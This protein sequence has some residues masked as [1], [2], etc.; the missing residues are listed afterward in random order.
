MSGHATPS[1]G[2]YSVI[3]EPSLAE[4][5]SIRLGGKAIAEIRLHCLEGLEAVPDLVKRLGGRL[6]L[7]GEGSNV[8]ASDGRLPLVPLRLPPSHE[9]WICGDEGGSALLRAE[10]GMRLPALLAQA[11]ILGLSGLEG[12]AGIPGSVGGAVA[13]NAGSFGVEIGGLAERVE[14]FS[15]DLGLIERP[16]G[17]FDFRYRD[18]RLRGHDGWFLVCGLV[19]RLAK[20]GRDSVRDG[21]REVYAKKRASQP[22]TAR[23]AGCVFKNPAPGVPA[24]RLIEEAGLKGHNV[25]GMRFS[26][27]HANFLVN[28][29]G[30]SFPEAMELM[31]LA[32]EKVRACSGYELEKEVKI[33]R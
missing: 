1:V 20:S 25:G 32:R 19:L 31:D 5:T 26:P 23:S 8:I 11:A 15:P 14:I 22:V 27:L 6:V 29:G 30:G 9:A 10:G 18:C 24:G 33:W 21:M 13:M 28:E 12:L 7:L 2:A 17:D 4:R 16:A 3:D